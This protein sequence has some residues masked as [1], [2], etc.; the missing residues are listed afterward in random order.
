MIA[1]KT[2]RKIILI[3]G[4]GFGIG[5]GVTKAFHSL[6]SHV[7][8][9]GRRKQALDETTAANPGM[10]SLTPDIEDPAHLLSRNW[11]SDALPSAERRH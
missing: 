6:G 2:T 8:I 3:T 7:I 9:A 4:G 10:T 1:M 5:R 11:F